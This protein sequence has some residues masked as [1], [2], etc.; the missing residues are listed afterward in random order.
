MPFT[1]PARENTSAVR[2]AKLKMTSALNTEIVSPVK[3]SEI[4]KTSAPTITPRT[5][6]PVANPATRSHDGVGETRIS[7][8]ERMKNFD[9]KK[10]KEL[11]AY[12]LVTIESMTIPGTTKSI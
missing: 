3:K 6:P 7:S 4:S 9:W 10:V 11:L 12:E 2:I 1:S 5:M 8:M